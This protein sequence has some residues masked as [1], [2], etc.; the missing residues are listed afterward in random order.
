MSNTILQDLACGMNGGNFCFTVSHLLTI[1]RTASFALLPT[2]GAPS[3]KQKLIQHRSIDSGSDGFRPSRLWQL[4]ISTDDVGVRLPFRW[5]THMC[6]FCYN[7]V[8]E[9][10]TS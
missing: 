6:V 1:C 5:Q 9:A 7:I 4:L 2:N 10:T 3:C 8:F